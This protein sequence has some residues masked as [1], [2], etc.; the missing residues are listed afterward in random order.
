MKTIPPA[1]DQGALNNCTAHA[2]AY[3]LKSAYG[4]DFDPNWLMAINARLNSSLPGILDALMVYGA[5]P[6]GDYTI[7]PTWTIQA[8]EWAE[9]YKHKLLPIAA[10]YNISG[11]REIKTAAELTDALNGGQY[12]V[13]AVSVPSE[14]RLPPDSDG[15]YRPYD[16][17]GRKMA[18]AMSAWY[19]NPDGTIRV[20]N[21]WGTK[22][23]DNGQAN[24]LAED[25]L[26]GKEPDCWAY[27]LE[28]EEMRIKFKSAVP[29]GYK[30]ALRSGPSTTTDY[31]YN[32]KDKCYLRAV[33]DGVILS[34]R[35]G[36]CEVSV[37]QTADLTVTGWVQAKYVKEED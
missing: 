37:A 9:K 15:I 10:K 7:A 22:W 25:I 34:K 33:D 21:S 8:R 5:L 13:F 32:G 18:H 23:G 20:L 19:V 1:I 17:P 16:L 4:M 36:W 12:V 11:Y 35:D 28:G 2:I 3:G 27:R 24:M 31:V 6:V 14:R 29:T 26:R 30:V